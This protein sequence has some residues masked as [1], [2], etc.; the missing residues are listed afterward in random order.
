MRAA[1]QHPRASLAAKPA[2]PGILSP[3]PL[4][5]WWAIKEG[6]RL[7]A[8]QASLRVFVVE[9]QDGERAA[10]TRWVAA[11]TGLELVGQ[12]A[13]IAAA[14]KGVAET[15]PDVVLLDLMMDGEPPLAFA[16][17]LALAG[18]EKD[19]GR[20]PHAPGLR[21]HV[22]VLSG[23]ADPGNVRQALCA[24]VTGYVAKGTEQPELLSA[25]QRV[26]CGEVV[27]CR[28]VRERLLNELD[29]A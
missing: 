2:L 6:E 1:R 25:I 19:G 5:A 29:G 20:A 17:D 23:Y 14:R 24:G 4:P 27:F 7:M 18:R 13:D 28:V 11:Q 9:D 15:T 8:Q 26:A 21:T 3:R 10:L 22:L 12:A 16:A